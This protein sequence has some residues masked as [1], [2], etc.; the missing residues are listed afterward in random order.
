MTATTVDISARESE[1]LALLGEHLSNAEIGARLF[2]SVRTVESHV[3]SLLRK[4]DAPDRRA[5]A[6]RASEL[7]RAD[8]AQPA[9]V[10]PTPLTSFVG[11]TQERAE[12]AGL[13]KTHR[14]VTALGPGGVGKTRLALATA[15]ETAGDFADGVWFVDLVPVTDPGACVVAGSVAA[16]LGLGEQ[17]GRAM[18][19]SVY[20]ALADRQALLVLDNCEHVRDGVAPFLERL[21]A[22]CPRLTVL[23]TSRA[24]LMVPFE[25]VYQVPPMSLAGDGESDAVA[26]FL[27]RVS[28]LRWPPDTVL[29]EHI[30]AVCERLD[31]VALA[32]ELAAARWP[33]LGLDGLT[34]G[35]SDQL[36][37]LSGGSRTDERHRS[38]RAA[39][40]WSHALLDPADQ[41]LLRRMAV[42]VA[43]F[44]V[45]AAARVAGLESPVVADG[46]ARLA[47]QSL[48]AVTATAHRTE[49][50]ALETIRQYG[51]ERLADAGELDDARARHLRWCLAQAAD[52]TGARTDLRARFDATA[53]DLR[54]ALAWAADRP[55]QRT[56]MHHLARHMAELSF[57]RTY[58]G[59]SQMR[60]E[61]AA[62]LTDD[63]ATAAELLRTAAAVAG[64]RMR[65][66][67]MYR[68][69]RAAAEAARQ[70]GDTAGAA[71][72]LATAATNAHRFWSKFEQLPPHEETIALVAQAGE[73]AG[74]D[75]AARAAVAL[76]EAGVLADAFGAAQGP[77]DNAVDD[78]T[79]RT[80]LAVD[81][82]ARTGDPLA[83][84]AALDA[85]TG[86]QSWAG[87]AFAAAATARRRVSLL[88]PLPETP[89]ATHELLD[90]LG[91]ATEAALGAGDLP[92]AR[93]WGRRLAEHPLLAEVGHRATSWLLV[94]DALAGDVDEVLAVGERFLEA[95]QRAG[96]PARSVLGPAVAAVAMVH[97]LRDDPE[98]RR[99]WT[100]ILRQLGTPPEHTYGY[101]AVFDALGLLHEGQPD[102]ALRRMA[103]EPAD[104]WKWV[105][106][107]WHHW[108]VALRAEAAVLAGSADAA[109]RVA[110]ARTAVA[111]NPVA[112]AIVARAQALL[113]GDRERL[114]ATVDAFDAAGCRYQSARTLVL[115]GG[116]DAAR[117]TAAVAALG[118]APMAPAPRLTQR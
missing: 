95:W 19:E 50:R 72:D 3:S 34:A 18:D 16:A 84:S 108:Y 100:A 48:L 78:T 63:P 101:G 21:L 49:Y 55:E 85:L 114:L 111:G 58:V 82:A 80:E 1:V 14:Q 83:E 68:L 77:A 28:E 116:S 2:I 5:L 93:R 71:R 112:D 26:L 4:V 113:D 86:A 62:A 65:G 104:V 33:T 56:D 90:A 47:E 87:D 67:D 53:D 94:V 40:D 91:M 64:C 70:A 7:T 54:A 110:A 52:M 20:A 22:T 69:H 96:S 29:R 81:L 45:D 107:I 42:F 17:P 109:D 51:I 36:R 115:A 89:A 13:L 99:D 75:P 15:A 27:D 76:A 9:P 23:T 35:L 92:A 118:L 61:Q 73:L 57:T 79:A 25:R 98:A 24:R 106:W 43:P 6:Q 88:S 59:E 37:L 31:G 41:A 8:H 30:A 32:I 66:E 97:G 102:L 11:R 38:V 44:T 39:L 46:L 74:G 60:Y 10:L 105:T 117:G 103:P 12:L